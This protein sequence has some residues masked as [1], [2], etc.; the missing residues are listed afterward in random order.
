MIESVLTI[1]KVKPEF[2]STEAQKMEFVEEFKE[3]LD[4]AEREIGFLIN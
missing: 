3:H 4:T 2:E 1:D